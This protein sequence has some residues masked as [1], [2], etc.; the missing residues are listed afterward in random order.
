M[1]N[2]LPATIE[3]T[4][5][6]EICISENNIKL[7][8]DGNMG[9]GKVNITSE[10]KIFFE[11][12]NGTYCAKKE[13]DNKKIIVTKGQCDKLPVVISEFKITPDDTKWSISKIVEPI[14]PKSID[15][16]LYKEV[17]SIDGGNTFI[18]YTGPVVFT[19]NGSIIADVVRIEDNV[20]ILDTKAP[21]KNIT[22]IDFTEPIFSNFKLISSTTDSITIEAEGIDNESGIVYYD[23]SK[24]DGLTWE[25]IQTDNTYTFKELAENTNYQIKVRVYNGTYDSG[26]RLFKDSDMQVIK[27]LNNIN[28]EMVAQYS[29]DKVNDKGYLIDI[30]GNGL[31][32]KINNVEVTENGLIF[33]G[34]YADDY[35]SIGE[36]NYPEFSYTAVFRV[37]GNKIKQMI[38]SNVEAGG[39]EIEVSS[40]NYLFG[41]CYIGDSYKLISMKNTISDNTVYVATLTYDGTNLNF[42]V[43]SNLIGTYVKEEGEEFKYPKNSTILMLGQNPTGSK[44]S[45]SNF[46]GAIY[47]ADVY[48]RSLNSSEIVI[49]HKKLLEDYQNKIGSVDR[50]GLLVEYDTNSNENT[51]SRLKD[52]SGNN[53]NGNIYGATF[54]SNKLQF[55]GK[56]DYVR[57]K[58]LNLPEFTYIVNFSLNSKK[59]QTIIGSY[60]A[61]GGGISTNSSN[62]ISASYYIGNSYRAITLTNDYEINKEYMAILTYDGEKLKFYLDNNL[63][64][65]YTK[66]DG[67]SLKYPDKNTE[68]MLGTNPKGTSA[69]SGFL[70]GYIT[71]VKIYNRALSNDEIIDN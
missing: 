63:I 64:G 19:K 17:Y 27:T 32:A 13:E 62:K 49:S 52:L 70:D 26:G 29:F 45:G 20:S 30:S 60:E 58:E 40:S 47:Y 65:T 41:G 1:E 51:S 2:S 39:C 31:D 69:Q 44:G 43:N 7:D 28:Y 71:S 57:I 25:G 36:M 18:E 61:G 68:L 3:F 66:E 50:I 46:E 33:D 56:N 10:G 55:D 53:N 6:N 22:K 37:K 5:N 59:A 8:V 48:S 54:T 12:G 23:Y 14:Y 35:V 15:A 38:I 11:L 67:D 24:D 4:C 42:Y 16:S 9:E 34:P 21:T